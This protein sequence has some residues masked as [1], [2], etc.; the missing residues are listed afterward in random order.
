LTTRFVCFCLVGVAG[1]VVDA[2][3]L[4]IL[5]KYGGVNPF[6][7][8][9]VSFVAAA[10]ST[11]GLNRRFT[12]SNGNTAVGKEWLR[13]MAAM[14]LGGLV[15]YSVFAASILLLPLVMRQPW[16]GV[17]LGSLAGLALNYYSS[18][19]VIFKR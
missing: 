6:L 16:L 1:F 10:S 2:G 12:F 13:Y 5:M 8:R 7:A 3:L 19:R 17:A 18:S 4:H 14:A 9:I 11:W 15:N